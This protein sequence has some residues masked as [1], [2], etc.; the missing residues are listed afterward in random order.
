MSIDEG[1]ERLRIVGPVGVH[2]WERRAAEDQRR[3]L[4]LPQEL[5]GFRVTEI[6]EVF[7][8]NDVKPPLDRA[9][10]V[11]FYRPDRG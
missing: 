11:G 10:V 3:D 2:A 1:L 8:I 7:D 9:A 4:D 6:I 5:F